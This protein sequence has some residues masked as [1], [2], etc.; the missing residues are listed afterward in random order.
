MHQALKR[1]NRIIEDG[2][3]RYVVDA[4]IKGFFNHVDHEWLKKFLEVRIGDPNIHRLIHRM[5]KAGIQDD[6]IFEQTEEG[7]PQGS[8]MQSFA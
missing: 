5:L 7:T 6:G 1:L 3:T 8:F 2:K 4:D